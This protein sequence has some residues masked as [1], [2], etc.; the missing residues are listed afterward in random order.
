MATS[1]GKPIKREFAQRFNNLFAVLTVILK[2]SRTHKQ[3][4]I[5]NAAIKNV[6]YNI[7]M[8]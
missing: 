8:M 1:D 6:L 4:L 2:A 5:Q 3:L 7:T